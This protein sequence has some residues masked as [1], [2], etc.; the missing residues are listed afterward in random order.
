M[1][2]PG[3]GPEIAAAISGKAAFISSV[4]THTGTSIIVE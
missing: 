1:I 2:C 3:C 4:F